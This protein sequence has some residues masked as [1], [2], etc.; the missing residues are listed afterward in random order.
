MDRHSRR[1]FPTS[2]GLEGRQL[3]STASAAAAAVSNPLGVNAP[4]G[5]QVD[6]SVPLQQTIE[7]K[8]T[9]IKNLPY[10]IGLL[11]RDHAVP[12]PMVQNIQNDLYAL[13]AQLHVGNPHDTATFNLDL[14]KAQPF[15]EIRPQDAAALNRDFGAVLIDAGRSAT[16]RRRPPAT[17]R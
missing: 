4:A 16:D 15:E 14:R 13:V 9:H 11:N 6:G 12:Q 10:F 5:V 3:L 7:A 2:E 1:Y 17:A 8:Q